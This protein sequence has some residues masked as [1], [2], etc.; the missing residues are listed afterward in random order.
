MFAKATLSVLPRGRKKKRFVIKKLLLSRLRQWQ[1]GDLIIL[2]KEARQEGLG[3]SQLTCQSV[4]ISKVN[5][6]RSLNLAREGRFGDAMKAL[7]SHGCASRD[8]ADTLQE[9]QSRHPQHALP[10]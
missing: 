7:G 10:Q 5:A 9:L 4:S 1:Q 3:Q 2:W 8:D 6:R